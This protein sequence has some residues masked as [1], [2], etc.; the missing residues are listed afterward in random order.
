MAWTAPRTWVNTELVYDTIMNTHVRDNLAYLK[1]SPTFD[2]NVT[3]SGTTQCTGN[4]GIGVAA[5]AN[6]RVFAKSSGTGAT[7]RWPFYAKD[8]ANADLFYIREDGAGFLKAASWTFGS[9]LRMKE[10]VGDL[11][12]GLKEV[13]RLKPRRFDYI[14]GV[15]D[16]IGF[17]AQELRDVLPELVV[18][19]P[20]EMLGIQ[21]SITPVLVKAIQ[22][23]QQTIHALE[24]R[25]TAL[26]K[27]R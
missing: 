17:I 20:G 8:S 27:E 1:A 13:L 24:E 19:L 6:A 15:K 18:E 22:E 10:H 12:Y 25:L 5:D 9:D 3:V 11:A 21:D 14:N 4:I 23:Q 2:G 26:E 7:N 16:Q